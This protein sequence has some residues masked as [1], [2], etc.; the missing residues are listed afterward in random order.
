MAEREIVPYG[1]DKPTPLNIIPPHGVALVPSSQSYF[2][3]AI[4]CPVLAPPL[5][6]L[7]LKDKPHQ[8][9]APPTIK[10][11]KEIN[12]LSPRANEMLTGVKTNKFRDIAC[13]KYKS[14]TLCT[15][16]DGV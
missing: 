3:Q 9:D 4:H 7:L 8:P 1:V 16:I 12:L 10:L 6:R 2:A 15:T 14:V 5:P 13:A 11:T